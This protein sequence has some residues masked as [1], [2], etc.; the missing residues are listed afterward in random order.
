MLGYI[1]LVA[2][3]VSNNKYK[4]ELRSLEAP[5]VLLLIVTD[6]KTELLFMGLYPVLDPRIRAL[7]WYLHL[8]LVKRLHS[9]PDL[10]FA[11]LPDR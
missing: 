1:D 9:Y 6:K 5:F 11:R 2:D 4:R 10:G 3:N 8:S 7:F